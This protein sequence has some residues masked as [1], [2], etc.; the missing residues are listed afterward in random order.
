MPP[1]LIPYTFQPVTRASFYWGWRHVVLCVLL[2]QL[3]PVGQQTRRLCSTPK[4]W[5][6][7]YQGITWWRTRVSWSMTYC[8]QVSKYNYFI[9]GHP[10]FYPS[11]A[12]AHPHLIK[13]W[14]KMVNKLYVS[15]FYSLAYLNF[16][17]LQFT[18]PFFQKFGKNG[19]STPKTLYMEI[20][21]GSIIILGI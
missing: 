4:Y 8:Q 1:P 15:R 12:N 21:L 16:I 18:Y 3:I 13:S 2:A 11:M 20:I 6:N 5:N 14:V 10:H 7:W 19:S 17:G 9:I